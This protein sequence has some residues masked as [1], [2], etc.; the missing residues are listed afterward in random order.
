MTKL[1]GYELFLPAIAA[2]IYGKKKND[3]QVNQTELKKIV[4]LTFRDAM[5]RTMKDTKLY[6]EEIPIDLYEGVNR[7]DIIPSDGFLIE[8]V[9]ELKAHKFKIPKNTYSEHS[10]ELTCCPKRDVSSAFFIEVALIAKRSGPCEFDEDFVEKYYDMI[11]ANMFSRLSAMG[12]QMW[13][14]LGAAQDYRREYDNLVGDA[15][16]QALS[17]GSPLKLQIRRLSNNVS[18]Y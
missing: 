17:S 2:A 16:R 9:M 10:I 3:N 15:K 1:V 6:R 18:S 12:Q 13:R 7:Y 11:L 5:I 14:S 4:A 8:S